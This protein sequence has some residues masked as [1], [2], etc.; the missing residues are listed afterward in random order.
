MIVYK[1]DLL[2]GLC[3]S[4]PW[5]L[6]VYKYVCMRLNIQRGPKKCTHPLSA[7]ITPYTLTVVFAQQFGGIDAV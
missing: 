6:N 5:V 2:L 4:L 7:A 3:N 1:S